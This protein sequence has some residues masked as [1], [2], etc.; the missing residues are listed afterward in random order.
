MSRW[1]GFTLIELLVTLAIISI[2]GALTVPM[3]QVIAQRDKEQEL[4]RALREVRDAIDAYKRAVDEGLVEVANGASGYPP[5]LELLANGV[6]SRTDAKGRK[7]Y[8]L[9]KVPR[10][11]M[12]D[13]ADI[14]PAAMWGKRSFA[15]EA[16]DPR[17]G[18]DVFDIHSRSA[19]VGL[20]GVPYREW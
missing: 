16:S 18:E 12:V 3:A 8:F 10:D 5:N 6:S 11:P 20:N 2:L 17:D 15:S 4:R 9:R 7:L 19:K 1:R 14:E 13:R